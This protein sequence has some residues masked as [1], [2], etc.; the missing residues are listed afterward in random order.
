MPWSGLLWALLAAGGR[1]WLLAL[2]L[3]P[4]QLLCA[5][6]LGAVQIKVY[7]LFLKRR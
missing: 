3:L 6:Y 2:L 7:T 4:P 1:F 5:V